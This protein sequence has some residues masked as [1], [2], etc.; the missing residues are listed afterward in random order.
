M[1]DIAHK[2]LIWDF[3]QKRLAEH[4]ILL[5]SHDIGEMRRLCHRVYVLVQGQVMLQGSP[6]EIAHAV[7]FPSALEIAFENERVFQQTLDAFADRC[8]LN[9]ASQGRVH[10]LR[11]DTFQNALDFL[12]R[13]GQGGEITYI[14]LEAP[15]LEPSLYLIF[16]ALSSKISDRIPNALNLLAK[17][18]MIWLP[19]FAGKPF[20]P[21]KSKACACL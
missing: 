16:C 10:Q 13:L 6:E 5:A 21:S 3:I 19:Y 9:S 4:G 14:R 12:H 8:E 20:L 1:V 11:F 2:Y 15:D 17:K 18:E 7:N